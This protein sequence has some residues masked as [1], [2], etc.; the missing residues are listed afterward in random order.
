MEITPKPLAFEDITET[1]YFICNTQGK[2]FLLAGEMGFDE[3]S[4]IKA[5]MESDFCRREM[6]ALYSVFQMADPEDIMD[7]VLKEIHPEKNSRTYG[8]D[9]I[10]WTG[11]MYRYLKLRLGISS[12]GI[13]RVIPLKDMLVYY[14]GMHTQDDEYFLDVIKDKCRGVR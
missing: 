12:A 5:Y 3:D 7:Y 14:V 10:N 2:L 6:D 8:P 4:F 11:Y 9:R 13:Y 1:E